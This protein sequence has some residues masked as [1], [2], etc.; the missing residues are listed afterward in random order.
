MSPASQFLLGV[1]LGGCLV[2]LGIIV[3]R[4]T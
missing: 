4:N 3:G 2:I 1:A